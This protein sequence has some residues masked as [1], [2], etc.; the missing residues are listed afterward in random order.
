M[1]ISDRLDKIAQNVEDKGFTKEAYAIDIISN[2]IEALDFGPRGE[3]FSDDEKMENF[4]TAIFTDLVA[5]NVDNKA[6]REAIL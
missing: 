2:T 3:S 4:N 6:T 1:R 5:E